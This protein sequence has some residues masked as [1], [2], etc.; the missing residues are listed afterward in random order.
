M[1]DHGQEYAGGAAGRTVGK[2]ILSVA[3][4]VVVGCG[5]AGCR[6]NDSQ[7]L[8]AQTPAA[9]V[10]ATTLSEP[11]AT[12]V[13]PPSSTTVPSVT[14]SS[15]EPP[16]W[17]LLGNQDTVSCGFNVCATAGLASVTITTEGSQVTAGLCISQEIN[18][19][20]EQAMRTCTG[21][22]GAYYPLWLWQG[23]RNGTT[24]TVVPTPADNNTPFLWAT[25]TFASA[26]PDA[27]VISFITADKCQ[28]LDGSYGTQTATACV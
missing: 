21:L 26:A 15:E 12:P 17:V 9:P 10:T 5:V 4:A 27:D 16:V 14:P 25:V 13:S 8:P 23:T 2:T 28:R 19:N 1:I 22:S 6:S 24:A 18:F 20:D 11:A 7:E 3:V